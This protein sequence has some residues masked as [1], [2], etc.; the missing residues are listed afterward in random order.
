MIRLV[1]FQPDIPQ[2]LGACMRLC[3]CMG[4]ELHVIEPCGFVLNDSKIKRAGMDYQQ[5]VD[6]VRHADWDYFLAYKQKHEGRLLIVETDG[7]APYSKHTFTP[8]DYVMLGRESAGTPRELYT[9]ADDTLFIPM[10]EGFRSLNVA[11]CAGM[12]VAEACR[13]LG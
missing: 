2:N 8:T 9:L 6:L 4:A 13:Q 7:A 11:M 5:H 10:R 1:L 3:A 12:V